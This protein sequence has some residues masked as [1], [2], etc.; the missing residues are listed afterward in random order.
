MAGA[1]GASALL[2]TA[3]PALADHGGPHCDELPANIT[4]A[5]PDWDDSLDADDDGIGCD[6]DSQPPWSPPAA[7][8]T[9]TAPSTTTTVTTAPPQA[10]PATPVVGQPSFTG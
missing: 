3:L 6:D 2:V 5:H 10:A 1:F 9:T 8:T 4:P 7:S